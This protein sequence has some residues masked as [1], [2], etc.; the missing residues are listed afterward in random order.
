MKSNLRTPVAAAMLFGTMAAALVAQP[1][2]AEPAVVFQPGSGTVVLHADARSYPPA[3]H[4]RVMGAAAAV[5]PAPLIERFV[6]RPAGRLLPGRELRFRL[7]G[8]PG[9]DAWVDIPGV[10]RGIDLEETR[11][12]VYQGSY[13]VRRRDDPDAFDRAVA[14]LRSGNQQARARVDFRDTDDDR[15]AGRD[16]RAPRISDLTPGNGDRISER[17]RA[18]IFARID[19][20]RSGVDP[21]TVRLRVDGRDVTQYARIT[22]DEVRYGEN[23]PRGRHT[24]ELMVRDRAG[25]AARTVWTFDVV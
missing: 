12:G 1:A 11:P 7:V 21:T 6:V 22:D 3:A 14:T 24:A 13:T 19:D 17:G 25:N 20:D 4:T 5:A 9:A 8:A 16:E 18:H 2:A 10:I 23:L 15:R